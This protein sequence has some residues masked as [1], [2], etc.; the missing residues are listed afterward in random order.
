MKVCIP[1]YF[2]YS[3]QMRKLIGVLQY[4]HIQMHDGTDY[5]DQCIYIYI[6]IYMHI[7]MCVCDSVSYEHRSIERITIMQGM[8]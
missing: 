5:T 6:N 4:C 1:V 7:Y 2:Y 3:L 8:Q